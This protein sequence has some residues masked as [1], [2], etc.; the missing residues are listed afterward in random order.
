MNLD[1]DMTRTIGYQFGPRTRWFSDEAQM[2]GGAGLAG[3]KIVLFDE[4]GTGQPVVDQQE[5]LLR[6]MHNL[7]NVLAACLIAREAGAS[8]GAMAGVVKTFTGVEHRLE[9]VR[10]RHGVRYYNDS[11]ATSPERLMAALRSFEEPIV[12]LAGGR[13]KHLPWAE[14]ARLIV[15]ITRQVILFGEA[16]E[17]I[18]GA[19]NKVR[20]ELA[21]VDTVIHRCANLDEAVKLSALVAQPGDV[22]LLSPGCASYDTFRDFAERGERFKAL[23]LQLENDENKHRRFS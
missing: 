8:I 16:T 22:V 6:G 14:A 7:Y 21:G 1:N 10:E 4:H 9:L 3:G 15:R 20:Q 18:A 19:L 2:A 13:D 23:V 11:I 12:L 5:V 17:I